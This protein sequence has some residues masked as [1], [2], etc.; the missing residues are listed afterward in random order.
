MND[1]VRRLASQ[2]EQEVKTRESYQNSHRAFDYELKNILK[3][4]KQ[5][6]RKKKRRKEGEERERERERE[7]RERTS[8]EE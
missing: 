6:G 5:K 4:K 1:E 3:R 8:R 7:E 2:L